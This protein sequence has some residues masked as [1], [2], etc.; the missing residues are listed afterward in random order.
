[1]ILLYYDNRYCFAC[2]LRNEWR[3]TGVVNLTVQLNYINWMNSTNIKLYKNFSACGRMAPTCFSIQFSNVVFFAL[4]E[5]MYYF[6]TVKMILSCHV[7]LF[8]SLQLTRNTRLKFKL[9][10][11]V[12]RVGSLH[13]ELRTQGLK[14]PNQ[15]LSLAA[16][17]ATIQF[18]FEKFKFWKPIFFLII[19]SLAIFSFSAKFRWSCD[20]KFYA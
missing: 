3:M 4:N 6:C 17:V 8:L 16:I 7:F 19:G 1:M 11:L 18:T 2:L 14:L 9:N 15:S 10:M 13:C 20:G 5:A 12:L